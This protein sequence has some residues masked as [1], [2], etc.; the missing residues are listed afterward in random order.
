MEAQ[1]ES[2]APTVKSSAVVKFD[3]SILTQGE[4]TMVAKIIIKRRFKGGKT[5]QILALL[6]ELRSRAMLQSGYISG[7][8]LTKKGYPNNMVVIATWQSLEDWYRWRENEERSKFE[9]M[10]EVYQERP[11]EYEEYTLGPPPFSR[12]S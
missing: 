10:L 8:T 9:A 3:S 4:K 11:A 2:A 6:N 1:H 7:E 12:E 5:N